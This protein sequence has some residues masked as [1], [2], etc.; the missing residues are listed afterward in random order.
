MRRFFD[1]C[2]LIVLSPVL[3]VII[4]VQYFFWLCHL[5]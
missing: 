5:L 4:L 1:V 3:L 2:L